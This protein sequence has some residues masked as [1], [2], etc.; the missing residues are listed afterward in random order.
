MAPGLPGQ[1]PLVGREREIA[2]IASAFAVASTGRP[3][4]VL[5]TGEPGAGKSR[6]LA[7]S[8]ARLE[9]GGGRVARGYAL[10]GEGVPPYFSLTRALGPLVRAGTALG[11]QVAHI[12]PLIAEVDVRGTVPIAPPTRLDPEAER[13]RLF[14]AFAELGA[15]VAAV[16]PLVVALDDMQWASSADWDAMAYLVRALD[17]HVLFLV[18]TREE[19]VWQP[20]FPGARALSEI[21]RQRKLVH[22]GVPPL[23]ADDLMALAVALVGGPLSDQL[24]DYLVKASGGNPFF[25]EEIVAGLAREGLLVEHQGEWSLAPGA[26]HSRAPGALQLALGERLGSLDPDATRTLGVAAVIG[27]AFSRQL[28]A[29]ALSCS[30]DEAAGSLRPAVDAGLIVPAGEHW[31]F[32]HDLVREAVLAAI[33]DVAKVHYSVASALEEQA[34]ESPGF[35]TPGALAYHWRMAGEAEKGARAALAASRAA[36]AV[37]APDEALSYARQARDLVTSMRPGPG[38]DTLMPE[39]RERLGEAALDAGEFAEAEASYR[40]ALELARQQ[41]NER[42]E[43]GLWVRLGVVFHRREQPQEA[44]GCF[45][46][47]LRLLDDDD[48]A[49]L[50]AFALVEMATI[51]GLTLAR[52]EEAR[53]AAHRALDIARRIGD[54][55]LEARARLALA[56]TQVRADDP[57]SARTLLQEALAAAVVAGELGLAAEAAAS[58]ANECYWR[59]ELRQ[60][61]QFAER[62]LALA[63]EGHDLFGL[64]HAHSWL[65][66]VAASQ[67]EWEEARS[68]LAMAGPV[69][70]R[71]ESPEPIAFVRL[72]ESLVAYRTGQFE[73]AHTEARLAIDALAPL[74]PATLVWYAGLLVQACLATGRTTEALA[75]IAAQEARLAGLPS[76]ALPARS[77]RCILGLAYAALG[78]RPRGLACEEA[79]RPFAGDFHWGAARRTLA[80]LA[81]LRGDVPAA[82]ADLDEAD[83]H[84]RREGQLPDLALALAARAGLLPPGPHRDRTAA[85]AQGLLAQLGMTLDLARPMAAAAPP[86]QRADFGL[87][88]RELEVLR[89]VAEGCTNRE[90]AGALVISERTA[91]NHLSHI[92]GKIG[93]DNRAGAAAFAIRNGLG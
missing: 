48:A 70:S 81:A 42:G 91:I 74:G 26:V 63:T 46:A 27:R 87:T 56:N 10:S 4:L 88:T 18:A 71:L 61:R 51:D 82:L 73:Q 90:I 41:A 62:R 68:Y 65:A 39:A 14:E 6:L 44:I 69:L 16:Q 33:Q 11:E 50:V 38:R 20:D 92:F 52:Y 30:P 54:A 93:V 28:L 43:G 72:V 8:T 86:P 47:G 7:E 29:A 55:S 13:F 19:G 31:T 12:L 22:I 58:L 60:S 17:A 34:S 66:L 21:N 67:G 79:L 59:G 80:A 49:A 3:R 2:A 37:G 35:E 57:A 77:A 76:S 15:A 75:E 53:E 64:R 1:A 32:R 45:A 24:G 83:Q 85:E 5:L 78:D 9:A 25:A 23:A 40:A 84:A 36:S 89:L